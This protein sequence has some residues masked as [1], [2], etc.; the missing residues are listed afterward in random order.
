MPFVDI[1]NRFTAIGVSTSSS[2]PE[3]FS[4]DQIAADL[5]SPSRRWP[6]PSTVRSTT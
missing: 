4:L 1:A 3:G 6:G 5:S 2:V